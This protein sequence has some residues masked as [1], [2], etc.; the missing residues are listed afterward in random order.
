[1]FIYYEEH[2]QREEPDSL[3]E[4]QR[5]SLKG[6]MIS[7]MKKWRLIEKDLNWPPSGVAVVLSEAVP[8][9]ANL[10][11]IFYEDQEIAPALP[12]G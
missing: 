5:K 11:S 3:K 1:M 8:E 2:P 6:L 7:L 4:K 10:S 9:Y 12:F